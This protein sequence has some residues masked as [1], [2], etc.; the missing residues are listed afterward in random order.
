MNVMFVGG[1]RRVSLAKRFIAAGF[2][3]FAYETDKNCPISEV[4]TIIEGNVSATCQIEEHNQE[5]GGR[6]CFTL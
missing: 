1:G 3:I 6:F 5:G 4:A 2:S